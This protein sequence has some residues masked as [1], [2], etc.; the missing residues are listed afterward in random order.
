MS[1]LALEH[2]SRRYGRGS[3]EHSAL[4]D[5]SLEIEAGELVAVWGRRRSGRSTLMRIASGMEAPDSGVVRFDG[6]DLAK[7]GAEELRS[8]IGY[9]RRTFR[10]AGGQ[11]VLDQL[12]TSQLTRGVSPSLAQARARQALTRAGAER[13]AALKPSELDS[14]EAV[15]A[16]IA[17]ALSHQPRL[18]VIDD[19][20]LGVDLL[21]RDRILLLLRSI[22]DDGVAVLMSVSE[23]PCLSRSDRALSL[24]D[25]ELR[26]ELRAAELAAVLPIRPAAAG[27]S[28]SA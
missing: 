2:V 18:L 16:V 15:R 1:L 13:S 20:T 17:R 26:G 21:D 19:P 11:L 28:A 6:H 22:A 27:E 9:C 14:S 12:V 24:D 25:G 3:R 4:H 5:V 10:P 7:R 23:T 8:G